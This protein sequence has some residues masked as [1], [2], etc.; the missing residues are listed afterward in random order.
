VALAGGYAGLALAHTPAQA[1]VV[2]GIAG[3]GNGALNPSQSTLVAT[4]APRELRHRATAWHPRPCSPPRSLSAL[5]N[6]ST[7]P[8]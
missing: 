5:V 3:V 7:R 6:A 1:F 4:L 2:A 8:C